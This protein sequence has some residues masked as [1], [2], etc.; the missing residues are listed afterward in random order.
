M[1]DRKSIPNEQA[2]NPEVQNGEL[3]N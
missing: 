3:G 1:T 2:M